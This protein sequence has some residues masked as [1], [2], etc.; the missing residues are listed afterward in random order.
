[1]ARVIIKKALT[2]EKTFREQD[3]G[4]WSFIVCNDANKVEIKKAIEEMFGV[5]V[6][7]VNTTSLPKKTRRIGRSRVHTKRQ[8]QKVARVS[9]KGK[10]AKLDL[11]KV[12]K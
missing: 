5:E 2:T 12:N 4:M 7:S 9:L 8:R 11:T 10:D 1:M 3:K 6:D